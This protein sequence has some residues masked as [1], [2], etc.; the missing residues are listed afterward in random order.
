MVHSVHRACC[1]N[2]NRMASRSRRWK[3]KEERVTYLASETSIYLRW[4]IE[5]RKRDDTLS[6]TKNKTT[7][8]V[9]SIRTT[10]ALSISYAFAKYLRYEKWKKLSQLTPRPMSSSHDCNIQRAL[11]DDN[12]LPGEDLGTYKTVTASLQGPNIH[13]WSRNRD[14]PHG[15]SMVLSAGSQ[16]PKEIS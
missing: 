12:F 10:K 8:N 15:R 9:K 16:V 5:F 11:D 4:F 6:D 1:Y 3:Q 14:L 13:P 7:N 2:S